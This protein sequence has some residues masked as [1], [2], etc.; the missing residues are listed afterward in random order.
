MRLIW[1]CGTEG[2]DFF[3]LFVE[4]CNFLG[5]R[6]YMEMNYFIRRKIILFLISGISVCI[7]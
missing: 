5:V 4:T 2:R 3:C 7:I 1:V 6:T